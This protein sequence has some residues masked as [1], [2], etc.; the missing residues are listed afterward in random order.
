METKRICPG[1][2][3]TVAPDVP[4]GLC[5]ECLLKTGFPTVGRPAGNCKTEDGDQQEQLEEVLFHDHEGREKGQLPNT[6]KL[7][8][9][10]DFLTVP[11]CLEFYFSI[12]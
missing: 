7:D 5:P 12:S 9:V 10:T 3:K 8:F 11:T 6:D 2:G 4:Q 1:C